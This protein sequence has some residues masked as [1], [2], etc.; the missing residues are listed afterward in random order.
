[1]NTDCEQFGEL[2]SGLIDG[3]LTVPETERVTSHLQH[4]EDCQDTRA[5]FELVDRAIQSPGR[6][7]PTH[8][9]DLRPTPLNRKPLQKNHKNGFLKRQLWMPVSVTSVALLML[10][11]V[12]CWP[13]DPVEAE[14]TTINIPKIELDELEELNRDTQR[15]S[16][17][18]LA[19]M[20]LQARIMRVEA[21]Q[22]NPNDT[23]EAELQS[24]IDSLISDIAKLQ[25]K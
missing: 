21:K 8:S 24:K 10:G 20:E 4:C 14:T 6:V 5:Q 23:I 1:M 12:I 15:N 25:T 13:V 3:E 18:T 22:L 16:D 11:L 17:I 2:I 9:E 7:L 19:T